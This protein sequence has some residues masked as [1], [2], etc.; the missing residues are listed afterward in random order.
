MRTKVKEFNSLPID[1]RERI[2]F[3]QTEAIIQRLEQ[4]LR[5][6]KDDVSPRLYK[7][8]LN[9]IIDLKQFLKANYEVVE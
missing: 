3:Y 7:K 6:S 4:E 2:I 9:K 1:E 5:L 8:I